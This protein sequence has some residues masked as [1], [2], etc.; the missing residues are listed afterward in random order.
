MAPVSVL[1][2][3]HQPHCFQYC[4]WMSRCMVLPDMNYGCLTC[5]F[6]RRNKGDASFCH[7]ADITIVLFL[8]HFLPLA[9]STPLSSFLHSQLLIW[10]FVL[11]FYKHWNNSVLGLF[12]SVVFITY[13]CRL[14]LFAVIVKEAECQKHLGGK[15]FVLLDC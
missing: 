15:F 2:P 1:P 4:L 10:G 11:I 8:K 14:W 6:K 7:D 3:S 5:N 9:L 13:S 12:S